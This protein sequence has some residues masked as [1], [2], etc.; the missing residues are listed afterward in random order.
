M[1]VPFRKDSFG[2]SVTSCWKT[3]NSCAGPHNSKA[4]CPDQHHFFLGI[5]LRY[6][7]KIAA[8]RS[9]KA[10]TIR[11]S[12]LVTT[13]RSRC[14]RCRTDAVSAK[15][16]RQSPA[17]PGKTL[18][19]HM[20]NQKL[21]LQ[22]RADTEELAN[23]WAAAVAW[24]DITAQGTWRN[25][26]KHCKHLQAFASLVKPCQAVTNVDQPEAKVKSHA[27]RAISKSLPP[28]WDVEAGSRTDSY[29]LTCETNRWPTVDQPLTNQTIQINACNLLRVFPI[30]YWISEVT[31]LGRDQE[32]WNRCCSSWG[33]NVGHAEQWGRWFCSKTCDLVLHTLY[34]CMLIMLPSRKFLG[35]ITRQN[36]PFWF[37]LAFPHK[38]NKELL[39]STCH[40]AF[41]KLL[42]CGTSAIIDLISSSRDRRDYL[43]D[44]SDSFIQIEHIWKSHES[45]T[46]LYHYTVCRIA[47]H[48][49]RSL[50]VAHGTR[51]L[52][53]CF[54]C[55]STKDRTFLK[56]CTNRNW[57]ELEVPAGRKLI[58][59]WSPSGAHLE[60]IWLR[61]F[62]YLLF[63]FFK[64]SNTFQH[65]PTLPTATHGSPRS[66][67]HCPP[68]TRDCRRSACSEWCCMDGV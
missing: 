53:H 41:Q 2:K 50:Y 31:I 45:F 59:S 60:P 5:T 52:D 43:F 26:W 9:E 16:P 57:Q 35:R 7:E 24:L 14:G 4:D 17:V 39:P 32:H 47:C 36:F 68:Q 11:H 44:D 30:E 3:P 42:R 1:V 15:L 48:T 33:D 62:E 34:T 37:L 10:S 12:D 49:S 66:W 25:I 40:P 64:S 13:R 46:T 67:Q 8:L 19:L 28:G 54:V 51:L 58:G 23:K 55:K 63:D 56:G 20:R 61:I 22:A 65:L 29:G 6:S 21:A 38:V 27:G 18:S